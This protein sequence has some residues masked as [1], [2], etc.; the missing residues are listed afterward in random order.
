MCNVHSGRIPLKSKFNTS[1]IKGRRYSLIPLNTLKSG[2]KMAESYQ[3]TS[4]KAYEK[5]SGD[6]Q[7]GEYFT[8]GFHC[9]VADDINPFEKQDKEVECFH[10]SPGGHIGYGRIDY[11]DNLEAIKQTYLRAMELG[12]YYGVN[13][14]A[15]FCQ[16]CG[17]QFNNCTTECPK[18]HSKNIVVID[19]VTGLNL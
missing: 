8:N 7:F 17:E 18:C 3:S 12:Y 19:R 14:D 2:V 11:P 13:F 6:T 4:V 16:D 15:G 5:Y 10:L 1:F 9:H